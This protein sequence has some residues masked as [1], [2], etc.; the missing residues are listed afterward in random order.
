MKHGTVFVIQ[1][2]YIHMTSLQ[3]ALPANIP[4][5]SSVTISYADF[6]STST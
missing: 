3:L 6:M 2:I 4:R 5:D 1:E